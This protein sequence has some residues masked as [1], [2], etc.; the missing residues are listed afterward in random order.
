M[1]K[2]LLGKVSVRAQLV[3]PTLLLLTTNP[4]FI[5]AFNW[6]HPL[7]QFADSFHIN[8]TTKKSNQLDSPKLNQKEKKKTREIPIHLGRIRLRRRISTE[9]ETDPIS[10]KN[11]C[12]PSTYHLC[13]SSDKFNPFDEIPSSSSNQ[14][15]SQQ[16]QEKKYIALKSREENPDRHRNRSLTGPYPVEKV[17]PKNSSSCT[18]TPK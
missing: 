16:R 5:C 9:F 2:C 1:Q 10:M 6:P 3:L 14:P 8:G 12:C 15:A 18:T 13:E 17:H 11:Y 4:T 7:L